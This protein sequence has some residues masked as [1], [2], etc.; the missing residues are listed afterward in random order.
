MA[1]L[2]MSKTAVIESDVGNIASFFLLSLTLF[3]IYFHSVGY[4]YPSLLSIAVSTQTAEF[5]I[6]LIILETLCQNCANV[7]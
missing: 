7:L 4:A 2:T 1:A 5:D 3:F 6:G